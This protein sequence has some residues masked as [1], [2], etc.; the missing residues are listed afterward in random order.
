MDN[1][2]LRLIDGFVNPELSEED[3]VENLNML[4]M[5]TKNLFTINQNLY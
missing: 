3:H 4:L 2:L 5:S 1:E